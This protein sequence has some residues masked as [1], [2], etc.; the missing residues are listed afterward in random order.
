MVS[1]LNPYYYVAKRDNNIMIIMIYIDVIL[2]SKFKLDIRDKKK[3]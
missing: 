3:F 1:K 2:I